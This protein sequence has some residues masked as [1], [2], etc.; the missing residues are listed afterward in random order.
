MVIVS[1]VYVM[2]CG[3]TTRMFH[4]LLIAALTL[5]SIFGGMATYCGLKAFKRDGDRSLLYASCGFTLITSGTVLGGLYV[6]F[7]HSMVELYF[8]Q[9]AMVAL[10]LFSIIYSI[11][12]VGRLAKP[13]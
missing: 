4:Q 6:F 7:T 12:H 13:R 9:S 8:V 10:G 1:G 5:I 3:S 11:S 2:R